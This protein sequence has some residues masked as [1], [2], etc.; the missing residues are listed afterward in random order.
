MMLALFVQIGVPV[1]TC[2][3]ANR[4][5]DFCYGKRLGKDDRLVTWKRS[6]RRKWMSQEVNET[7]DL[8]DSGLV[9]Y[10]GDEIITR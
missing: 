5:M 10:N 7:T 6:A 9:S 2:I 8:A 1:C 3:Y 4:L